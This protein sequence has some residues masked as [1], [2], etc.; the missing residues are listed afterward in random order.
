MYRADSLQKLLSHRPSR[1]E[2][3]RWLPPATIAVLGLTV[4]ATVLSVVYP[5]I[6]AVLRRDPEALAAGEWW[7]VVTPLFVQPDEWWQILVVFAGLLIFGAFTERLFGAARWL[8]LYFGSGIVGELAGYAWQPYDAGASVAVAGL[9]GA[10]CV[11][12]LWRGDTIP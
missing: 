3:Q 9:M 12:L 10:T 11:W 2:F 4:V 5:L 6:L 1:I 8:V 7:R